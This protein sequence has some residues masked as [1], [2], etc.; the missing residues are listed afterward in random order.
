MLVNFIVP[1]PLSQF[2]QTS[3]LWTSLFHNQHLNF[4]GSH[5]D[6][7]HC[8]I[9]NISTLMK[10]HHCEP[11]CSI[12]NISILMDLIL[13]NLTDSH[14]IF[15]WEWRSGISKAIWN[16]SCDTSNTGRMKPHTA[17]PNGADFSILGSYISLHF[18]TTSLP[19]LQPW[20]CIWKAGSWELQENVN[21]GIN[22]RMS[23]A[24]CFRRRVL[25]YL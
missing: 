5:L 12:T 2:W 4:D 17:H 16:S 10:L 20:F 13:V 3:S 24:I 7:C 23:D 25:L 21:F 9:P 14:P 6:E 11:H 19:Y 1:Y 18:S 22:T 15:H 8:S